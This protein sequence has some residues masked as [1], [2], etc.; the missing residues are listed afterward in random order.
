M[1]SRRCA[2]SIWQS[3]SSGVTE[4]RAIRSL[5]RS[6]TADAVIRPSAGH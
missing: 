1:R 6:S 3:T 4:G 2:S 5:T